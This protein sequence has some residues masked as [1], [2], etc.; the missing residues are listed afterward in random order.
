MSALSPVEVTGPCLSKLLFKVSDG[1]YFQGNRV[2]FCAFWNQ[3]HGK[4][5]LFHHLSLKENLSGLK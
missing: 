4:D 5:M 1:G 2:R 3:D